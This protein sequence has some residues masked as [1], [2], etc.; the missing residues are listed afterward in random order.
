MAF[1]ITAGDSSLLMQA[2]AYRELSGDTGLPRNTCLELAQQS[3]DMYSTVLN[4]VAYTL[5][6]ALGKVKDGEDGEGDPL[7]LAREAAE[8][9]KQLQVSGLDY[10]NV[11]HDYD[12]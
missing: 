2:A 3:A 11:A 4:E 10:D 12:C 1:E 5:L 7:T 6:V 9:L 8:K